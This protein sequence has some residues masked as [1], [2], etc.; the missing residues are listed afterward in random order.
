MKS[1]LI[2][3]AALLAGL[4]AVAAHYSETRE[5]HLPFSGA[6]DVKTNVG[7]ID[8]KVWD[9]TWVFARANVHTDAGDEWQA[10][11]IAAAVAIDTTSNRIW[12]SGPSRKS[13][14][15]SYE[16]FI[17][18]ECALRLLTSVGAISVVDVAGKIDVETSVGALTL[19]GLSGEV[20]ARTNVG[21]ISIVLAG[22]RW[23]GEGLTATTR[24]G[25]IKIT[26]AADYSARFD[27]RTTL[28]S[29]ATD[30]P[31][32]HIQSTDFLSR[33][34]LFRA[35]EGG[36]PIQASTSVGQIEL[37]VARRA[38]ADPE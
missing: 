30:F 4:P 6:I 1:L 37:M 9:N 10:R 31:G 19:S 14:A 26:A 8:V 22:D 38:T 21:A 25:A 13:W 17:P 15:V 23:A 5:I 7:A 36:A 11:A 33:G 34:I 18:R 3:C 28:G 27:L 35:G 32:A 20:E 24:T 16:I 2:L 29:A 12:A